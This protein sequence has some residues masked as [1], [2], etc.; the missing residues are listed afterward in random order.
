MSAFS[1]DDELNHHADFEIIS[2]GGVS[3]F[4]NRSVMADALGELRELGYECVQLDATSWGEPQ[5]HTDFAAALNFPDYYGHNLNALRDC[6]SDVAH[7]EYGWTSSATGLAVSI[8]GYGDLRRRDE[9]L[10]LLAASILVSTTRNGLLLGHRL[11]WLLQ[12][13]ESPLTLGP[14]DCIEARL[15]RR[16]FPRRASAKN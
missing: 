6:L 5:L 8:L 11:I 4:R 9:E 14:L 2:R 12:V 3:L 7:G 16:E 10:A 15:D 13:S 1:L